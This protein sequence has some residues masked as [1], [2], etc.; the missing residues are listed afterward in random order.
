MRY[1]LTRL[2]CVIAAVALVVGAIRFFVPFYY[3]NPIYIEKF[4]NLRAVEDE[5]SAIFFG[6]SHTFRQLSPVVFDE[7]FGGG[8][9]SYNM[10]APGAFGLEVNYIVKHFME[11]RRRLPSNLKWL[12]VE[13]QLPKPINEE[14]L[15][16]PKTK[17]FI[18]SKRYRIGVDFYKAYF[19]YEEASEAISNLRASF[20]ENI[21][22]IGLLRTQLFSLLQLHA[23]N[24]YS[25]EHNDGFVAL[26][27][28]ANTKSGM[29][30]R[31]DFLEN[32][33]TYVDSFRPGKVNNV[34]LEN[35]NASRIGQEYLVAHEKLI[36][37][38][39]DIDINI[40]FVILPAGFKHDLDANYAL[41]DQLPEAN[42]VDVGSFARYPDFYDPDL[43]FDRGHLNKK[44]A[45]ML[46]EALVKEIRFLDK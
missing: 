31:I 10:G 40:V 42:I 33:E 43:Y 20:L 14:N 8:M 41:Y 25:G 24:S 16:S 3:G 6:S 19:Q 32:Q 17:Y 39:Q 7:S 36:Q 46:S 35:G 23:G 22:N 1:F 15:H 38:A 34:H 12:I 26:D 29:Q 30:R 45:E 2:I 13:L 11:D 27:T 21:L 18:D 5:V 28:I 4:K 37:I 44:G 9:Q